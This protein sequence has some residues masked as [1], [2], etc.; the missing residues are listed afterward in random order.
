MKTLFCTLLLFFTT[1]L[2]AKPCVYT[3]TEH[4]YRFSTYFEMNGKESYEGKVIKDAI[5]VRTVY[6]LYDQNGDYVAQGICRIL[7][8][9]TICSW[10]RMVD[11]Y[12]EVGNT[13]GLFE[14]RTLTTSKASYNFYDG[15][16]AYVAC[17]YLNLDCS[18]FMIEDAKKRTIA[19]MKRQFVTGA[20]DHWDITI[21]DDQKVDIRLMKLFSA[22]AIDHQKYFKPDL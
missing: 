19:I 12:D 14:G 13:I 9:G 21:Y 11:L 10:A 17:A 20:I 1:A 22:F 6:D 3:I 16:G 8:L 18:A 5:A 7:S 4:P 2:T 15:S